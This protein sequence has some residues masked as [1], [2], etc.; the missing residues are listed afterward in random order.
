M[1]IHYFLLFL[2]RGQSLGTF[3]ICI[4]TGQVHR[5]LGVLCP[6]G[7][8]LGLGVKTERKYDQ[9]LSSSIRE[10]TQGINSPTCSSQW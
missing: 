2:E 7:W 3:G 8:E 9:L 10:M 6:L 5:H 4:I 1:E